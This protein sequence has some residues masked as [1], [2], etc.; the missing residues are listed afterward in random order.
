[1]LS[2]SQAAKRHG[3]SR[4]TLLYYDR[5]GIVRPS[6]RTCA[7]YRLYQEED[8]AKL[9]LVCRYRGA[10]MPL[11][12]ILRLL[13]PEEDIESAVRQALH[14]RLSALNKEIAALRRQQQ[15]V[16]ELLGG[17]I[18]LERLA[19]AMTKTKWISLLRSIGMTKPEMAAWHR[20]FEK[21]SPEAH[22]DFLESL[23]IQAGEIEHIRRQS[24]AAPPVTQGKCSR[25]SD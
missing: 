18:G 12:D 3:L 15:A 17:D 4:S 25:R 16:L 19:R 9:E 24:R 21:Q 10:G 22:Q 6:Y 20:A 11:K 5:L 14:R 1:M 8:L 2:I 13:D 23:G 7:G